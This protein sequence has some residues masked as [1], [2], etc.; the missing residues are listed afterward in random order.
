MACESLRLSAVEYL[1][2]VQGGVITLM[3][4][5]SLLEVLNLPLIGLPAGGELSSNNSNISSSYL[6]LVTSNVQTLVHTNQSWRFYQI[7]IELYTIHS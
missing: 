4:L 6:Y 5:R 1:S 2:S 3:A 7:V